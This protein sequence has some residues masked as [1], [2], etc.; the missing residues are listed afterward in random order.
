MNP[1]LL[2]KQITKLKTDLKRIESIKKREVN[3]YDIKIN[4]LKHRIL[5]LQKLFNSKEK[6]N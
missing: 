1:D 6:L 5:R 4:F 3:K 2:E